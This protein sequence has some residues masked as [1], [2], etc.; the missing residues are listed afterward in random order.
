M[1][2]QF[3]KLQEIDKNKIIKLCIF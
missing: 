1:D 3:K 2:V